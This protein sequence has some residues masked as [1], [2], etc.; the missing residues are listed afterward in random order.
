MPK[1]SRFNKIPWWMQILGGATQ[2]A[3]S[4][5]AGSPSLT[6]MKRASKNPK[7]V[8]ERLDALFNGDPVVKFHLMH[9]GVKI[10]DLVQG[11]R[12]RGYEPQPSE[13][14]GEWSYEVYALRD[15]PPAE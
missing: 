1:M 4:T 9:T 15:Q 2:E 6:S 12:A 10:N 14:I 7:V 11:A 13:Q 8:K 5:I 3:P